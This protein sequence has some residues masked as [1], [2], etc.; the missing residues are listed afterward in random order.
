MPWQP[1]HCRHSTQEETRPCSLPVIR[2]PPLPS[3]LQQA[4]VHMLIHEQGSTQEVAAATHILLTR[5]RLATRACFKKKR[6]VS[7]RPSQQQL[8]AG[9]RLKHALCLGACTAVHG[10]H[11]LLEDVASQRQRAEAT[12]QEMSSWF[13]SRPSSSSTT[14]TNTHTQK[15]QTHTNT[16][17]QKYT[18]AQT[19][20]YEHT[21]T[22]T[23]KKHEHTQTY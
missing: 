2:D 7:H 21:H 10:Q 16:Q 13:T 18:H 6:A 22:Q 9:W 15:T 20:T 23:H 8:F 12:A 14:H 17:T 19:H 1:Q 11:A 4:L 3:H 5:R